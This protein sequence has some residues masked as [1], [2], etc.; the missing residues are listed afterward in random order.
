[1]TL[2]PWSPKEGHENAPKIPQMVFY[3]SAN[4]F[5]NRLFFPPSP[6]VYYGMLLLVD[7]SNLSLLF[8]C[9]YASVSPTHFT[10]KKGTGSELCVLP[11]LNWNPAILLSS[12][13][14]VP[15]SKIRHCFH[16]ILLAPFGFFKGYFLNNTSCFPS[17]NPTFIMTCTLRSRSIEKIF[18]LVTRG[19][20]YILC[21]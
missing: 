11:A 15:S 19:T 16:F 7:L 2:F 8:P 3:I 21:F 4:I 1:M 9:C 12:L 18:T 14:L 17:L 5:P 13:I 20:H 10:A 6:C